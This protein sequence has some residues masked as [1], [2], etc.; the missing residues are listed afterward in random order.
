MLLC[1]IFKK[2][3]WEV[4]FEYVVVDAKGKE[5]LVA[6]SIEVAVEYCVNHLWMHK[7]VDVKK[8]FANKHP[9]KRGTIIYERLPEKGKARR[10]FIIKTRVKKGT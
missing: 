7:K 3:A 10:W 8:L 2:E 6:N 1:E 9:D 4:K 5:L